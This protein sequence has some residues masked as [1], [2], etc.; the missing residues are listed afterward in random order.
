MTLSNDAKAMIT[1]NSEHIKFGNKD[2]NQRMVNSL[3]PKG[4]SILINVGC[5]GDEDKCWN[6]P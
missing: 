6:L 5:E 4:Y 2:I 3:K 1:T